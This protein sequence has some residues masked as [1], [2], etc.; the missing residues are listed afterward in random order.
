M[1]TRLLSCK[2]VQKTSRQATKL[3]KENSL[4]IVFNLLDR[5]GITISRDIAYSL[6]QRCMEQNELANARKVH[7]LMISNRLDFIPVLGDHL[8]RLFTA[9]GSLFD[10]NE[11][12]HK[13]SKPTVYTWN[14]IIQAHAILG[15]GDRAL[16]LYQKMQ[17]DGFEPERRTF[18]SVLK[19]CASILSLKHGRLIHDK[20]NRNRVELDIAVG[21]ALVDCY[22]KCGSLEEAQKVF[23]NLSCRNVVSWASM[24]SG[25]VQ[26]GQGLLSYELFQRMQMEGTEPDKVTFL[27]VLQACGG[28][29]LIEQGRLIHEQLLETGLESDMTVGNALIDMYAKCGTV[30]D[31]STL[32]KSSHN[33]D[34]VTWGALISGYAQH[35]HDSLALYMFDKMQLEGLKPDKLVFSSIVKA[36]ES[37]GV[38]TQGRDV[39]NQI[40]FAGLESDVVVGSTLVNMFANCG[41]LYEARR[42]F[43]NLP[44]HDVVSWGAIIAA[45]LDH[46]DTHSAFEYFDRM[47]F[48][49]MVPEKATM[50][51]IVKACGTTGAF[52]QV[53]LVHEKIIRCRYESDVNVGNTIVDVYAKCGHL[54]EACHLFKRLP[55][56]TVVSWGS[57]ITAYAKCG[58]S[59]LALDWFQDFKN[60]GIKPD[61]VIYL[62]VLMS[63]SH[64]G[65]LEEGHL[66]FKCMMGDHR[67][68]PNIEHFNCLVDILGR[69]GRLAEAEDVLRSIPLGLDIIGWTSLLTG[70]ETYSNV[71]L[72]QRCY[73][74][75]KQLDPGHPSG[76]LLMSNMFASSD[77]WSSKVL[78]G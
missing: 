31:A 37:L 51:S 72:G 68:T 76:Y 13:V 29:G 66:H 32:F 27:W 74:Q 70:C 57:L 71:E 21:N 60:E 77:A 35:G 4:A 24:I 5:Q 17:E 50:I 67:I 15:D 1:T 9:C 3:I 54:D 25:Y 65:L 61:G 42:V 34:V 55:I 78:S 38:L 40:I 28:L 47:L 22:G 30:E 39:Y 19:A 58:E 46:G 33:R 69:G 14:A 2:T 7:A 11:V 12:F 44:S 59:Q 64:A 18:S 62:G 45:W 23:D 6:L 41:S 16:Q 56:R 53:R 8:I 20:I 73:K 49:D 48:E 43:D 36:C 63:C 10:A 75:V 26:H 52:D